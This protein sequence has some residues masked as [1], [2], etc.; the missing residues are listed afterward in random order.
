MTVHVEVLSTAIVVIVKGASV[1]PFKNNLISKPVFK[2]WLK[3][4]VIQMKKRVRK[5][6]NGY[7][8]WTRVAVTIPITRERTKKWALKLTRIIRACSKARCHLHDD[9]SN[10]TV[11]DYLGQ[12][13]FVMSMSD[14]ESLRES[15]LDAEREEKL[16][17]L[18]LV[19]SDNF[20]HNISARPRVSVC[21]FCRYDNQLVTVLDKPTVRKY[22]RNLSPSVPVTD[23]D[24]FDTNCYHASNWNWAYFNWSDD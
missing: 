17:A 2:K 22:I 23:N 19:F 11:I 12:R 13:E 21:I 1:D 5:G 14:F 4:G 20:F 8:L 9:E 18:W 6:I 7:P 3:S 24:E 10:G 15:L 16:Y